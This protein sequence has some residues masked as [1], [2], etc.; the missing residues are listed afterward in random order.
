M[1]KTN[2]W[3]EKKAQEIIDNLDS[4]KEVKYPIYVPSKARSK[5]KLTTKALDDVNLHFYVVVEPQ[6]AADYYKEYPEDKIVVME[7]ND[8]GIGYVRNA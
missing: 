3:L 2:K 4:Q 5:I 8:Q 1:P 7:K 6:D